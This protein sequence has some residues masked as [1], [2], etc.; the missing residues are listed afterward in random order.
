LTR[1]A[2][3]DTANATNLHSGTQKL[4]STYTV[5]TYN[6][7]HSVA[8]MRASPREIAQA[9]SVRSL[10]LSLSV[11]NNSLIVTRPTVHCR[12]DSV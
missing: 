11:Y 8:F 9:L 3:K 2:K 4:H 10:Y 7:M 1:D 6:L 12:S 5:I